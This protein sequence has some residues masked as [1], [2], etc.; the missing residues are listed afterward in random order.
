MQSLL[1][2]TGNSTHNNPLVLQIVALN[3]NPVLL[4]YYL[5]LQGETKT[6]FTFLV[7]Y[8]VH[9]FIWRT[10]TCTS[11]MTHVECHKQYVCEKEV[12]CTQAT[13]KKKNSNEKLALVFHDLVTRKETQLGTQVEHNYKDWRRILSGPQLQPFDTFCV[14]VLTRGFPKVQFLGQKVA[15]LH[16]R[17]RLKWFL[18][19][20]NSNKATYQT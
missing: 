5:Q 9:V 7:T 10:V 18:K 4:F 3:D 12:V 2:L 11:S 20:C 19:Q 6:A 8:T 13:L 15:C 17:S 16:S 14:S 1:W